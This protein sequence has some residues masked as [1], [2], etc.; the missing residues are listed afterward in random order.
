MSDELLL[1][2]I[3]IHLLL[4]GA[5]YLAVSLKADRLQALTE[6]GIVFLLPGAGFLVVCITRLL[7]SLRFMQSRIDPHKLMNSNNVFTN[8]ISYDENVIPL[9]DTF[10][11][12]DV[13]VKRKVFLDA[14][15]QNVLDNP[16]V[17]RMATYDADREIAYYAVSMISGHIEELEGKLAELEAV[18]RQEAAP[19]KVREYVGLL[20]DYLSQ[21]FVDALTKREKGR[22]YVEVL[23]RLL[24]EEPDND[25]YMQA[26]INQEILLEDYGEAE[27][28]C[29]AFQQ[30]F[31][32]REEPY[33]LYMKLYHAMR[34]PELLQDKLAELK[35]SRAR[36]SPEALRILRYWG[37][38]FSEGL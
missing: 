17:L 5:V 12:D 11:V 23:A 32:D 14:V 35:G 27:R 6:A 2:C 15:K 1:M 3:G 29:H 24:Q 34:R 37:G 9:H 36:L 4:T 20:A 30:R 7:Y 33:L 25:G 28:D 8:L 26:K 13:Q 31:P 38:A 16:K 10:L 21:D 19:E 22:I 18:L